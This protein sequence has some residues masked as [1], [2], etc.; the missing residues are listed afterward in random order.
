MTTWRLL[1]LS[2][3]LASVACSD[4]HDPDHEGT[5]G[6]SGHDGMNH[7]GTGGTI[8]GAGEAGSA[9]T[10]DMGGMGGGSGT[11]STGGSAGTGGA[12]AGSGG[13]TAGSAGAAQSALEAPMLMHLMP[14][15]GALHVM[16]MNHQS[17]CDTVEGERKSGTDAFKVVF[18]VP[19]EADNKH[20]MTATGDVDY[21]YRLRCT[22]GDQFSPYSPEMTANPTKK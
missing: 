13:A 12:T 6:T 5:A 15:D 22:K 17:D 4:S 14:M 9:G 3:L 18:S 2:V 19:G 21:T 20:D 7:A 1:S 8:G 11:T 10:G 16:W